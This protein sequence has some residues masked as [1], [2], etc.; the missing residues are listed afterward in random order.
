VFNNRSLKYIFILLVFLPVA[1]YSVGES[2]WGFLNI[3]GTANVIG[4]GNAYSPYLKGCSSLYY[5]PAGLAGVE[6]IEMSILNI[7]WIGNMRYNTLFY[8][9]PGSGGGIGGGVLFLSMP[10]FPQYNEFGEIMNEYLTMN[11]FAFLISY[12]RNMGELDAGVNCKYIQSTLMHQSSSAI[13]ADMGFIYEIY[14]I[15]AGVAIQNLGYNYQKFKGG[16]GDKL[17]LIINIQAGYQQ[18][19]FNI[20]EINLSAD[21]KYNITDSSI[22]S[23]SGIEWLLKE[24]FFLRTGFR[25]FDNLSS[26]DIG[27]GLKYKEKKERFILTADYVFLPV[28]NFKPVHTFALNIKYYPEKAEVYKTKIE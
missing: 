21:I 5:N 7:E 6:T 1:G 10:D 20:S 15:S 18:S 19:L 17:P 9:Q 4:M 3:G 12:A 8:A 2:S 26:W 22:K 25:L 24:L 11:D 27:G 13:A 28:A 23:G 14:K 16:E